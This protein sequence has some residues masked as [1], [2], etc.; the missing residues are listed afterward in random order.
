VKLWGFNIKLTP[1]PKSLSRIFFVINNG[2]V[3]VVHIQVCVHDN[4]W[5]LANGSE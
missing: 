4:Q 2:D 1:I 3:A 5:I